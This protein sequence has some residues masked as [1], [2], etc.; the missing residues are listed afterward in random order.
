MQTLRD[1]TNRLLDTEDSIAPT[2]LR[3]GL[4][5]VIFAHGAQKALGWFGGYGYEGTM[6]YL[7]GPA[8]LPAAI[9]FL[10]ILIEFLGA[11][12]LIAGAGGRLAA[13]GIGAV[14]VGAVLTSHVDNGFFMNWAGAQAGEGYEFHLLAIALAAGI[15]ITGSGAYSV[16][17]WLAERL[18]Q[19]TTRQALA[20]SA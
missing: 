13:V 7:T 10:V 4:G 5:S 19:P 20:A 2:I 6:G 17:R 12:A 3:V 14:M 11:A 8:G 1:W 18:R 16:D 9:A 15:T